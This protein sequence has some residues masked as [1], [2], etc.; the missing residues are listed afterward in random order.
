MV[1]LS[2]RHSFFKSLLKAR[3]H[4]DLH[5]TEPVPQS[6]KRLYFC[7]YI[8][9]IGLLLMVPS[10]LLV[11]GITTTEVDFGFSPQVIP[12]VVRGG[13]CLTFLLLGLSIGGFIGLL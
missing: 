9:W 7:R 11:L 2:A 6:A 4:V 5:H 10:V 12:L 8:G 1:S 3:T 13:Y